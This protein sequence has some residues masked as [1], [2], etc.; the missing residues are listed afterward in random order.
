MGHIIVTLSFAPILWCLW[1][2]VFQQSASAVTVS[3]PRGFLSPSFVLQ[4][5][6]SPIWSLNDLHLL[7]F[8]AR[9]R[10]SYPIFRFTNNR[11]LL[12]VPQTI[13]IGCHRQP[14]HRTF[15]EQALSRIRRTNDTH[16]LLSS[17]HSN[18]LA[19][20]CIHWRSKSRP[21]R[22]PPALSRP[23]ILSSWTLWKWLRSGLRT[24]KCLSLVG[25]MDSNQI[26][27]EI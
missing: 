22:R 4:T 14:I 2:S 1:H 26:P 3:S 20:H 19:A 12:F 13:F 27:R 11:C 25:W 18:A 7:P 21:L 17:D 10:I 16:G 15:Y 9:Q 24:G 5:P 6:S 8:F 23:T